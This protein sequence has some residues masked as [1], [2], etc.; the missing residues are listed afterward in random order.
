MVIKKNFFDGFTDADIQNIIND[1][2][3]MLEERQMEKEQP[4]LKNYTFSG[5]WTYCCQAYD[6]DEAK[7]KF[8]SAYYE[9]LD[10]DTDNYQIEEE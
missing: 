3:F 1:L 4:K 7:M 10:I 8:D 9:Q 2:T 6:L 5:T